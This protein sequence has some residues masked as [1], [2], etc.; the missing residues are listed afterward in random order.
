PIALA[1]GIPV[2][3]LQEFLKDHDWDQD[4]VRDLLQREV[5]ATLAHL[6]A[7]DLGTLGIVDETGTAKKGT[8]TP[9]V[10][11]QGC[12]ELGKPDTCIVTV[13]LGVARGRYKT[14]VDRDLFLPQSWSADRARARAAGIPDQLVHRPKWQIALEQIDRARGNGLI[15]DWL[16]FDE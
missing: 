8:K 3:T 16:T 5:G 1:A 9:G 10:Q 4:Q 12:A 14:L 11:R 7:A 6:P 13:P 2:R 15:L